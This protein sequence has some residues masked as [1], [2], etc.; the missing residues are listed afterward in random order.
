MILF[1][2]LLAH[3]AAHLKG[4][5]LRLDA[6]DRRLRFGHAVSPEVVAAYTAEIAWPQT[7]IVGAFDDGQLRGVA[8]L[9]AASSSPKRA[10]VSVT[11]EGGY[12]DR[13]VGTE[14]V[15]R[16][17]TIARN[18]GFETLHLQCLPENLKMRHV[19]RKFSD[20]MSIREGDVEVRITNPGPDALSFASELLGDAETLWS[21]FADALWVALGQALPLPVP[22][23]SSY[24]LNSLFS[25]NPRIADWEDLFG[26]EKWRPHRDPGR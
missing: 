19:A 18:R 9:R 11:V 20:H 16:V 4:H 22:G 10:E 26:R 24:R 21:A 15:E 7:W 2:K 1:R 14:L 23:A 17:L 8:E 25:S 5:L 3:D 13:G 12:Q 6:A